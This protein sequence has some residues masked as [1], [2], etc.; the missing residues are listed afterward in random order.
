MV[1]PAAIRETSTMVTTAAMIAAASTIRAI[2]PV[3]STP[4]ALVSAAPEF[5]RLGHAGE[6]N[7]ASGDGEHGETNCDFAEHVVPR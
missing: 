5:V 2:G 6:A 1:A 3:V 7:D 4:A